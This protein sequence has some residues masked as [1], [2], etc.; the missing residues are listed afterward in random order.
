MKVRCNVLVAC[1]HV[2]NHPATSWLET[3]RQAFVL[4]VNAQYEQG[5]AGAAGAG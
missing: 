3:Q 5:W 2:A 1:S 4:L